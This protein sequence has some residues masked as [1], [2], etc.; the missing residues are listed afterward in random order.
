MLT[1]KALLGGSGPD[2]GP[3]GPPVGLAF[4]TCLSLNVH[5]ERV[6]GGLE[7]EQSTA[8]TSDTHQPGSSWMRS[9]EEAGPTE[10]Q[11]GGNE[12]AASVSGPAWR[13]E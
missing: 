7:G 13:Q 11:A 3:S 4:R 5:A 8:V 10:V 1:K 6:H 2:Q 12:N 9:F